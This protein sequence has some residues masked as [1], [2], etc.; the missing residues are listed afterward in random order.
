M[1]TND[2]QYQYDPI[3]NR[4]IAVKRQ[5]SVVSTNHYVA[6]ELNQY[7][8][9]SGFQSQVFSYDADGNLTNANGWT[10]TWDA[11]NRL[12]TASNGTTVVH[13]TY[14]YMSRRIRKTTYHPSD[15]GTPISD[16]RFVYDAWNMV[17]EVSSQNSEVSTNYYVW[18]LDLSGTLQGAGG[19][20]GLLFILSSDSCLLTS[21][22]DA[23]GN[24]TDYVDPNGT[25]VAHY[26]YDPYGNITHAEGA[27]AA[28]MPYRFSTKYQDDETG[29]LYY[30]YRFYSPELGRWISRDPIGEQGG[31]NL[32][33]FVI[34]RV[35]N[36]VDGNGLSYKGLR[37]SQWVQG[38]SF[39]DLLSQIG[40]S[41]FSFGASTWWE[42][43]SKAKN[44]TKVK[45]NNCED[46]YKYICRV[47][48]ENE[49][50]GMGLIKYSDWKQP[51]YARRIDLEFWSIL[52]KR[53]IQH[54]EE[55]E[56]IFK[57]A[58]NGAGL[59]KHSES[60]SDCDETL[61]CLSAELMVD[62]YFILKKNEIDANI[63][64]QQTNYDVQ[65][66]LVLSA[67]YRDLRQAYL[68]M[69]S[70]PPAP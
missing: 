44:V 54:E 29:L 47:T 58:V 15:L 11:E 55:H 56:K 7:S 34:N 6:N 38:R 46:C 68:E 32:F 69:R 35:A 30:G 12:I 33:A 4:K 49:F 22:S 64:F 17:E 10:F 25:L 39:L 43:R 45:D 9:V 19:V 20:G 8:Q 23:N 14:D 3:G 16:R 48:I 59:Q 60:G 26:Q 40:G 1:G 57:S 28:D 24:I 41:I 67:W 63:T 2:Y 13:N 50:M 61:A 37:K 51:W 18:G 36:L 21:A 70:A 66:S 31:I 53:A 62:A 65:E 27:L 5:N 42:E 52:R